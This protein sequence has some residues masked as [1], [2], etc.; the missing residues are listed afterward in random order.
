MNRLQ[1]IQ[2]IKKM[3][4]EYS[5]ANSALIQRPQI[6]IQVIETGF[7]IRESEGEENE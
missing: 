2:K 1:K 5:N 6:N 3:L 7:P 4:D